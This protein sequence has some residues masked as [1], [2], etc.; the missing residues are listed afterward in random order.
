MK[1]QWWYEGAVVVW[2]WWCGVVVVWRWWWWCGGS[3]VVWCGGKEKEERE[4]IEGKRVGKNR[5]G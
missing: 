3:A 1:V 4:G 2:R 5:R